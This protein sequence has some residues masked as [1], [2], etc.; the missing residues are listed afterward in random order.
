[1]YY[2]N[3]YT[4]FKQKIPNLNVTLTAKLAKITLNVNL[5]MQI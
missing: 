3:V 5:K 1:M 2:E 4:N